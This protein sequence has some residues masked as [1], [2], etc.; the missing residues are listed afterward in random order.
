MFYQVC[1]IM[2]NNCV[3][4]YDNPEEVGNKTLFL[5]LTGNI[6]SHFQRVIKNYTGYGD[7]ALQLLQVQCSSITPNDHHHF[8]FQFTT[9]CLHERET[10]TTFL[11]SFLIGRTQLEMTGRTFTKE[12][13][14]DYVLAAMSSTRVKHSIYI[15]MVQILQTDWD[16]GLTLTYEQI[17]QCMLKLDDYETRQNA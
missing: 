13:I 12:E 17:D 9:L 11:H 1:G 5:L 8:H 4:L 15:L 10:A 7:K 3:E 16:R 2:P 14:V 6:D